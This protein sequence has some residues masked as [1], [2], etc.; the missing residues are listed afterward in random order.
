[1]LLFYILQK[2]QPMIFP[3]QTKFQHSTVRGSSKA[4]ISEF[5]TTAMFVLFAATEVNAWGGL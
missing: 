5:L 3:L 2:K 4:P 1:M